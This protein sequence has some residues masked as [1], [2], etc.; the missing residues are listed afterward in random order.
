MKFSHVSV[1][2]MHTEQFGELHVGL[3]EFEIGGGVL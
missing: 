2:G 3:V 1:G